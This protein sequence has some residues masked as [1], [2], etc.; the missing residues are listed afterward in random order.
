MLVIFLIYR[1]HPIDYYS[2]SMS[3][4]F[5]IGDFLTVLAIAKDVYNACKDGPDEYQ[6]IWR[7]A[8][9]LQFTLEELSRDA[10]DPHSLLNRKGVRRRSQL[11]ELIENCESTMKDIQGLLGKHSSLQNDGL[12]LRR[13]WDV[14]QVG[15]SDLDDL[16]G[17]L[18]FHISTIT[19]FMQSLTSCGDRAYDE[20]TRAE[21]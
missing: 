16:R 1:H 21:G 18:T 7:E 20:S 11:L 6:E 9:S 10:T 17:K 14:Y 2:S 12:G 3:F 5:G 19:L 13:T 8:R 4:G 15:S